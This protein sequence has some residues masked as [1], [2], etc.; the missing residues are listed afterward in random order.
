MKETY[1]QL[2]KFFKEAWWELFRWLLLFC[3]ISMGI[4]TLVLWWKVHEYPF[5]VYFGCFWGSL[6]GAWLLMWHRHPAN[7]EFKGDA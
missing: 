7:P 5:L 6:I 1:A 2:R 3:L 4:A